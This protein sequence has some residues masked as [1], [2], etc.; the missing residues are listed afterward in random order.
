MTSRTMPLG[1]ARVPAVGGDCDHCCGDG[2][3]AVAAAL[4]CCRSAAAAAAPMH[5]A[6]CG[7]E[8]RCAC[9][10]TGEDVVDAAEYSPSPAS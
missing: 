10:C 4:E 1:F 9:D 8:A 7:T 5:C 3:A 6:H 2:V